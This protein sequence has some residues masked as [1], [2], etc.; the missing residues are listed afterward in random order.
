MQNLPPKMGNRILHSAN[1][2]R[3]TE[4]FVLNL[5]PYLVPC[6]MAISLVFSNILLKKNYELTPSCMEGF[7]SEEIILKNSLFKK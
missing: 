5:A 6:Q 7:C 1:D 4:S 3:L 2:A